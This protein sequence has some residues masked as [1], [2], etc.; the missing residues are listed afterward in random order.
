GTHSHVPTA[1]AQVL[2]GGTAYQTD[3]GMCGDYDSVIGMRKDIAVARFVRKLPGERLE[4][5]SGEGTLCGVFVETDDRSGLAKSVQPVRMG[6]RL[7]PALPA[8]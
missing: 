6:G 5:G 3:A 7:A 4:P 1:D 2:P 8:L